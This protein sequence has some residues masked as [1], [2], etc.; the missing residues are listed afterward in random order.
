MTY[1][2]AAIE[3]V[4]GQLLNGRDFVLMKQYYQ[5]LPRL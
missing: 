5:V 2:N 4:A 1:E 3:I